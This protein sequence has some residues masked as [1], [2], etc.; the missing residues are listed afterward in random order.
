MSPAQALYFP[1]QLEVATD[2]FVIEDA[3]AID[4]SHGAADHLDD[5]IGVVG[6]NQVL[7]TEC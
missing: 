4:D 6:L 5:F 3:E 7:R 2:L 1:A